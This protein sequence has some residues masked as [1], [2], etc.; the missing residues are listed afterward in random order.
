MI[1]ILVMA[2]SCKWLRSKGIFGKKVDTMLVWKARQDSL[3]V[4]DSVKKAQE[5]LIALE[6]ARADSAKKAEEDW[7]LRNKYNIIIGSFITPEYARKYSEEYTSKGYKTRIMKLE[8]TKFEMVVAE[9][10]ERLGVAL[11][12]LKMFQDSVAFDSWIYVYRGR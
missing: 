5:R 10:H 7:N 1:L 8:G 12:R 3:R 11:S 6:N 4:I 9:A 2:P